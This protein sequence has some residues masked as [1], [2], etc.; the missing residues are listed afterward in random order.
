MNSFL[1]DE[2]CRMGLNAKD[3]SDVLNSLLP[4]FIFCLP[5]CP[6]YQVTFFA[7]NFLPNTAKAG[8]WTQTIQTKFYFVVN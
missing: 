8:L 5:E 4:P 3:I 2:I 6:R 1:E 7:L